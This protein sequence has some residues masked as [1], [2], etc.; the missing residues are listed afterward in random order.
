MLRNAEAARDLLG[1]QML[2]DEA[3][4][5]P[6][7]RRKPFN[8]TRITTFPHERRGKASFFISSIG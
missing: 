2:G 4:A 1:P 6:L 7:A 3:Q 5:F 8:R